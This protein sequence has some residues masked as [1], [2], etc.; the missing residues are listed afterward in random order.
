MKKLLTVLLCL[1]MVFTF[2]ACSSSDDSDSDS[3]ER[4]TIT[5]WGTWTDDQKATLESIAAAFNETQD[6][7]TVV[8]EGQTYPM[9]S[10]LQN[11]VV[12]NVGPDIIID[13]A[14]TAATYHELGK[15]VDLSQYLSEDTINLLS[16]GAYA[17]SHSYVDDGMYNYPIVLSGPVLWYNSEILEAAG[18]EVP[19]TWE[20][21]FETSKIISETVTVVTNDDGSKTYVT[22]GSGEHIYGFCS[23]SH[24]DFASELIFGL[25]EDVY[26]NDTETVLFNTESVAEY[27]QL[28]ADGCADESILPAATSDYVSTDFNSGIVAMYYGSVAGYPYLGQY[29]DNPIG[30]ITAVSA[31]VPSIDGGTAWTSAWN[32][33]VVIFDYDDEARIEGAI[34]FLEYFITPE[35]NTEWCIACNYQSCISTT[36]EYE[37]YQEFIA[38]NEILAC[39]QPEIAGTLPA[40]PA[41]TAI[42]TALK[43]LI[44]SVGGGVDVQTALDEAVQYVNE[45]K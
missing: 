21:L 45:N 34:A 30:G 33:G 23:D 16:D 43:N 44:T 2:T 1:A 31:E 3:T 24:T 39:L 40:V 38:E 25:G 15:V 35:V 28:Y 41:T 11:A 36:L 10:T 9:D 37:A 7:Y 12:S 8:Y 20:E 13:Y 22:D 4:T 32:R 14:S 6:E 27:L 42:R 29:T 26:D 17:E 19:T 18:V 5:I